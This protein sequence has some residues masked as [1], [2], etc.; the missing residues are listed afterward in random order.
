MILT[1]ELTPEQGTRLFAAARMT[2]IDLPT[3]VRD[4]APQTEA[5]VRSLAADNSTA[6]LVA[7]AARDHFYFTASAEQFQ[8]A[9]D[10]IAQMNHGLPVLPDEAF[11]RETLYEDRL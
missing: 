10:E 4:A 7:G 9:I 2:G 6:P 3:L 8:R 11:D 1:I 5:F